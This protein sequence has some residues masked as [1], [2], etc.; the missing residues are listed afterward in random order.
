M[1]ADRRCCF[2]WYG[3]LDIRESVALGPAQLAVYSHR[4]G[5]SGHAAPGHEAIDSHIDLRR[6]G[7]PMRQDLLLLRTRGRNSPD[8]G[9]HRENRTACHLFSGYRTPPLET[10]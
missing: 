6:A 7:L 3:V 10:R 4:D 8:K 1:P 5:E 2:G 9:E